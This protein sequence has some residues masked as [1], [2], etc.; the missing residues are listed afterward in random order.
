M[1]FYVQELLIAICPKVVS[2]M[3]LTCPYS[4]SGYIKAY[5]N[6]PPMKKARLSNYGEGSVCCLVALYNCPLSEEQV[7]KA[8]ETM[9]FA[10][11]GNALG[12]CDDDWPSFVCKATFLGFRQLAI[13]LT[14]GY[15]VECRNADILVIQLV[16]CTL[17]D[18][19]TS[20]NV[21]PCGFVKSGHMKY[22]HRRFVGLLAFGVSTHLLNIW[23]MSCTLEVNDL[24]ANCDLGKE[25][26]ANLAAIGN[27]Q[28][29]EVNSHQKQYGCTTKA[30]ERE[31][32]RVREFLKH[33]E[34]VSVRKRGEL[35]LGAMPLQ[36]GFSDL[37]RW[38]QYNDPCCNNDVTLSLNDF[39]ERPC[40]CGLV[41][42]KTRVHKGISLR[43]EIPCTAY[44]S[45]LIHQLKE[46]LLQ[47][48][49]NCSDIQVLRGTVSEDPANSSSQAH[50]HSL[51]TLHDSINKDMD[52]SFLKHCLCW[53]H[54]G[55]IEDNAV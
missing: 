26:F 34:R 19:M 50:F 21:T 15:S 24:A 27:S 39:L 9:T 30:Y 42:W 51:L 55:S 52:M 8:Q 2:T 10:F 17:P 4:V 31:L 11:V 40:T 20:L 37:T 13:H 28:L 45:I 48:F 44:V 3:L 47:T 54:H 49:F 29:T 41:S 22:L 35:R 38:E 16:L 32:V 6:M 53:I 46:Q 25:V 23:P 43:S 14:S 5:P 7:A 18:K 1:H 36:M 33:L 12:L